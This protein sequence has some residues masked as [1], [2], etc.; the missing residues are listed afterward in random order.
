MK[1]IIKIV[2]VIFILKWID[3]V[4]KENNLSYSELFSISP[5]VTQKKPTSTN[6][7]NTFK[8]DHVTI[9][10]LGNVDKSDLTDAAKIIKSFYGYSTSIGNPQPIT[11]DMYIKGT[12]R[13]LDA[14]FCIQ[15]FF[16]YK[17]TLYIV[18]KKLWANGDYLRGY[19]LR[20][21]GTLIVRGEKSFLRETI[22]HELGHT[23][24]LS[25]CNDKTCIMAIQND[26]YDSGD[27]CNKC[28]NKLRTN[29]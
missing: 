24:G 3:D 17:K 2:I 28:K 21:A 27:F 10:P 15:K 20:G 26:A 5:E 4:R 7:S 9:I 12:D 8:T 23:L 19:A 18:D 6:K 22:I 16:S 13:I 25:H 1:T 11:E 29:E 14:E